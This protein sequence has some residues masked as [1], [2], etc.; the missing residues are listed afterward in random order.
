MLPKDVRKKLALRPGSKLVCKVTNGTILLKPLQSANGRPRLVTD[1]LTG[2]V[3]TTAP[4]GAIPVTSDQVRAAL[5]DF[6]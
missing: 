5:S 2:L 6:P 1:P 3:V 4:A